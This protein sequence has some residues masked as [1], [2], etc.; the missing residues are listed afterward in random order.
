MGVIVKDLLALNYIANVLIEE[1]I[2]L[3]FVIVKI[4]VT[5]NKIKKFISKLFWML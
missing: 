2:A 5:L 3:S 1:N 4:V